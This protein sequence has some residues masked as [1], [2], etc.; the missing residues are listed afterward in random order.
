MAAL[1]RH[2][3]FPV[4][5]LLILVA[6]AA[7]RLLELRALAALVVVAKVLGQPLL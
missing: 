5:A 7:V 6:A 1:V 3:L 4:L 2:H